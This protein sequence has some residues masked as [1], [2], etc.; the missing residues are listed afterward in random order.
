MTA[1]KRNEGEDSMRSSEEVG[2]KEDEMGFLTEIS[3]PFV[4]RCLPANSTLILY[5][6]T[7]N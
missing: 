5:K 1:M 3:C 4:S 2:D 7:V 6:E